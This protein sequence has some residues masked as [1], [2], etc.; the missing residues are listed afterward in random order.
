MP[1]LYENSKVNFS[2]FAHFK[3]VATKTLNEIFGR[4]T[5]IDVIDFDETKDTYKAVGYREGEEKIPGVTTKTEEDQARNDDQANREKAEAE[6]L[7]AAARIAEIVRSGKTLSPEDQSIAINLGDEL[8]V[9]LKTEMQARFKAL[10]EFFSAE[11]HALDTDGEGFSRFALVRDNETVAEGTL[12][13]LE[14]RTK[15]EEKPVYNLDTILGASDEA[16]KL[17]EE[18]NIDLKLVTGTGKDGNIKVGDVREY[19]KAHGSNPAPLK[20]NADDNGDE[21][22]NA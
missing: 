21:Q 16:I 6:A 12:A 11:L 1:Y 14:E 9:D 15:T 22:S 17:A 20:E 7:E 8:F 4:V 18:H 13:E 19:I 5:P 2:N 10:E 3:E